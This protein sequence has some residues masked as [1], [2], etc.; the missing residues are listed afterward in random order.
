MT[1][2]LMKTFLQ[3]AKRWLPGA[4]ISI[5]LIVV[6]LQTVDVNEV[7]V[8]LRKANR[9]FIIIAGILSAIWLMVRGIVW[10]TLLQNRPS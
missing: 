3:N 1:T 9:T 10:R 6:I 8:E 2:P 5:T 7:I 4:I